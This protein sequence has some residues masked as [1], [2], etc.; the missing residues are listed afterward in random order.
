MKLK[1]KTLRRKDTKKFAYIIS[2]DVFYTDDGLPDLMMS[3]TTMSKLKELYVLSKEYN[4]DDYELIDI[5]I[6]I[7]D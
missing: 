3:E 4:W 7:P 6:I 2:R 1:A 5:E